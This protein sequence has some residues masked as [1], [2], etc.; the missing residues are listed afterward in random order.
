[1]YTKM[2]MQSCR[3]WD[4]FLTNKM[5][6]SA[7]KRTVGAEKATISLGLVVEAFILVLKASFL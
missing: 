7:A 1:M 3:M 6:L 5:S 2:L 4:M